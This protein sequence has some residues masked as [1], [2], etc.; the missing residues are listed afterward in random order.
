[1]RVDLVIEVYLLIVVLDV[2]LAWV[3]PDPRR[4]PRRITHLL[5]EPVQRLV[6][7]LVSWLP[8][9][10]WDLSPLVVVGLL[11][12]ARVLWLLP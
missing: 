1:M 8:A 12:V 10:G 3:T 2:M 11:G 9:G 6:R 7:P 4:F 5:T